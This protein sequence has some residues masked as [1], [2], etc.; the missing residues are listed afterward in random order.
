MA[1]GEGLPIEAGQNNC[2]RIAHTLR[3]K[4]MRV[5]DHCVARWSLSLHTHHHC[6]LVYTSMKSSDF[7]LRLFIR[8]FD[9]C[10]NLGYQ[11]TLTR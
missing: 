10:F 5:C 8:H 2:T 9:Y 7:K 3:G 1:E 6:L 4:L 11:N